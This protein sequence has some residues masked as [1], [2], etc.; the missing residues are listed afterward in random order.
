MASARRPPIHPNCRCTLVPYVELKDDD[1]NIVDLDAERPAAN[2]DFDKLAQD[3]YNA[4]A[5]EKGWSRRWDDLSASTRL[6]YYY[7]AQKDFEKRTGKPAY[8]QVNSNL[9]FP[10]YFKQQP[11]SFK[12][13]W[14]GA[15][16]YEA[17]KD[18]KL[19]EKAIFAPDL[20]YTVSPTSLV[21]FVEPDVPEKLNELVKE[22]EK[23]GSPALDDLFYPNGDTKY[24]WVDFYWETPFGSV[25]GGRRNG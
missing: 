19:T 18:G 25:Q 20:A 13:A 16:R 9:S 8:R 17:Y 23:K 21:K 11:D 2:A 6:K 4:Q 15:K 10:E 3:S 5:K 12:R 1:G 7:Q 14:L 24:E 22:Y